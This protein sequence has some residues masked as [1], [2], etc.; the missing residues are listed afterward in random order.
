ML[1]FPGRLQNAALLCEVTRER[2]SVGHNTY[3]RCMGRGVLLARSK[4]GAGSAV[5]EVSQGTV[6]RYGG[7]ENK[8]DI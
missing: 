7:R 1:D 4:P 6:G 8:V 2:T 5:G 3:H